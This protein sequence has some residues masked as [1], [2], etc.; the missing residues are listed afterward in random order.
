MP[1]GAYPRSP[2]GPLLLNLF[3]HNPSQVLREMSLLPQAPW[4]RPALQFWDFTRK[5]K[6]W[7]PV[8]CSS[9]KILWNFYYSGVPTVYSTD[10][11]F[12]LVGSRM[13]WMV[14]PPLSASSSRWMATRYSWHLKWP[15]WPDFLDWFSFLI[16]E[17]WPSCF[18]AN[19]IIYLPLFNTVLSVKVGKIPGCWGRKFQLTS[20]LVSV[21][22]AWV[23]PYT[24]LWAH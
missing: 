23:I 17:F 7:F 13:W 4:R 16:W 12:F 5:R 20:H 10:L 22:K 24:Y 19:C 18:P 11:I 3:R 1:E 21:P 2:N 6:T 15:R 9:E 8:S 14:G